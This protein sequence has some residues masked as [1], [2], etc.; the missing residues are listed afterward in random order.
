MSSWT[1]SP[2]RWSDGSGVEPDA[3]T[4][5]SDGWSSRDAPVS[6]PG[7]A[8]TP[9][10]YAE[11]L[12]FP[13]NP[14][15]G[16]T[17]G[18]ARASDNGTPRD[19]AMVPTPRPAP[20]GESIGDR[21][22]GTFAGQA[23]S[24]D[25]PGGQPDSRAGTE[26]GAE[27]DRG[28]QPDRPSDG[29]PPRRSS[30]DNTRP[31]AAPVNPPPRWQETA[32]VVPTTPLRAVPL[33][34]A[35][36][37]T[38]VSPAAPRPD[39]PA[40]PPG[41]QT[42]QTGR[43]PA[44]RPASA[45][46]G[47]R[48][49]GAG[50]E[51]TTGGSRPG[52]ANPAA[53]AAAARPADDPPAVGMPANRE[54]SS[55][56][57]RQTMPPHFGSDSGHRG[58]GAT[59][60][61]P[62]P[63][64]EQWARPGG[65]GQWQQP[66]S[67][68]AGAADAAPVSAAPVSGT[69][70]SAPPTSSTPS[71]STPSSEPPVSAPPTLGGPA[72]GGGPDWP[73][74]ESWVS[75]E[76]A[77][78]ATSAEHG[79]QAAEPPEPPSWTPRT[80]G[81]WSDQPPPGWS[82]AGPP[83]QNWSDAGPPAQS[84]SDAGP[85]A[86][87]WSDAGPPPQNWSDAGPPAQSWSDAGP[88]APGWSEA[89]DRSWSGESGDRSWPANAGDQQWPGAGG[90]RAWGHEANDGPGWSPPEQGGAPAEP[91]WRPEQPAPANLGYDQD[92]YD[93]GQPWNTA[94]PGPG[95]EQVGGLEPRRRTIPRGPSGTADGGPPT[96]AA[97]PPPGLSADLSTPI[98]AAALDTLPQ[99]VPADPDVPTVPQP[100]AV[101]PSAET[102]ELARIAS[103][104]RRGD[105]TG[106][107]QERPEGFDVKA[108]LAAV[109]GVGGVRDASLR[110]TDAGAHSLRLDLAEGA[111]PAEVS[112]MVARLLQERMGLAAAPQNLPGAFPGPGMP[113]AFPG[114]GMPTA[115]M[116]G[117]P[118]AGTQPADLRSGP[119]G[120]P[121]SW[122]APD[123]AEVPRRRRLGQRPQPGYAGVAA[124]PTSAVPASAVPTSALPCPDSG[125]G[126]ESGPPRPLNP[127][128]RPGPR[129]VLNHV[130]VSTFGVDAT[131]EVHLTAG[132]RTTSGV[133]T[134]PAVDSYVLRLCAVA[135]ASAIEELLTGPTGTLDRGR[136]F[137]EHAA[138]VPMGGCE[139]AV[140][141][142]LLACG[143]WVEQLAGSA[144]VAGDPRQ[145]VVRATLA[146]V[147]RRL[148]ALLA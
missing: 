60:E 85:P 88:P 65:S 132:S 139:V 3:P 128:G 9:S 51:Q 46:P 57:D 142:V 50:P 135:A 13:R 12:Q 129:V 133:A 7:W 36:S 125:T 130:Q 123:P 30:F 5:A 97:V 121:M 55:G 31:T 63:M 108:I 35:T 15:S 119:D 45:N 82:D 148:D 95:P 54:P 131:V 104:L 112:R 124:V 56:G 118:L 71:S 73:Y 92:K 87:S 61:W 79:E 17:R 24:D 37:P 23:R 32:R 76:P 127:G 75:A 43:P 90:D 1:G 16:P 38:P 53:S 28:P 80:S 141:V 72:S 66:P 8:Q 113:G 96:A 105:S 101:E 40:T 64:T 27:R 115:P 110:T 20:A 62:R 77:W 14:R 114:P 106:Q 26:A 146:A 49:S 107:P 18:G 78:P 143:G 93:P 137:V 42:P 29:E 70:T 21:P 4:R 83:P 11:V 116:Q 140:V 39:R 145:A 120:P 91:P 74:A 136:C 99:R 138:V 52:P 25:R 109:R 100:P 122:S 147:N 81:D 69:P 19:Q 126:P 134:G 103:H 6:G 86:Q 94:L 34:S 67:T 59:G 22:G 10:G 84:W 2:T 58:S 117:D 89:G 68:S 98:A 33:A 47:E 44:E 102:P 48:F 41:F 144:V 111:D